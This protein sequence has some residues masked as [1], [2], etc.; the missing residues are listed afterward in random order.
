MKKLV[1]LAALAACLFSGV[2]QSQEPGPKCKRCSLRPAANDQPNQ[3]EFY[4]DYLKA[5]EGKGPQGS[6]KIEDKRQP[7]P[8]AV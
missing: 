5:Q 6:Q 1:Y 3:Y 8:A 7:K 2:V 4:E